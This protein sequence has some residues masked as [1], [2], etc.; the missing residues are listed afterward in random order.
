MWTAVD[1]FRQGILAWVLGDHSA[2]TFQ[3]LWDIVY[4]WKCYFYVT[5]G[6]KVYASFVEPGDHIISK[7]YGC[8]SFGSTKCDIRRINDKSTRVVLTAKNI[9][10]GIG[11]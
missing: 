2:E 11:L 9:L 1:H 6:W 7:T 5:D 4:L 8:D 10:D 3:P